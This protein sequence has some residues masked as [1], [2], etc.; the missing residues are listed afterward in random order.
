MQVAIA[1][2]GELISKFENYMRCL[3]GYVSEVRMWARE[4]SQF[5]KFKMTEYENKYSVHYFVDFEVFHDR[6]KFLLN[7]SKIIS[8]TTARILMAGS[9]FF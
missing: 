4:C 9:Y 1:E 6:N 7:L 8:W 2:V 3:Q 5:P